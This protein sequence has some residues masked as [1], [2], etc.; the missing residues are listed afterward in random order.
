MNNIYL[1]ELQLQDY[2][3]EEAPPIAAPTP[4]APTPAAPTPAAPTPAAPAVQSAPSPTAPT[5]NTPNLTQS[6]QSP[7][8]SAEQGQEQNPLTPE[9]IMSKGQEYITQNKLSAGMKTQYA[10]APSKN[11]EVYILGVGGQEV[12]SVPSRVISLAGV[13]GLEGKKIP[14][15]HMM[16]VDPAM[17]S[18]YATAG[19][20][21][22]AGQKAYNQKGAEQ[23]MERQKA[24]RTA[25]PPAPL[26]LEEDFSAATG[27]Q[28]GSYKPD[29]TNVEAIYEHMIL[30]EQVAKPILVSVITGKPGAYTY[31][32]GTG[33]GK[34][35]T[36]TPQPGSTEA[37]PGS[38]EPIPES[39]KAA[40]ATP[41]PTFNMD[42]RYYL[43]I[44]GKDMSRKFEWKKLK[45]QE[46]RATFASTSNIAKAIQN[47]QRYVD[48][49][50]PE[51]EEQPAAASPTPP[52]PTGTSTPAGTPAPVE[53]PPTTPAVES[54]DIYAGGSFNSLF[55]YIVYEQAQTESV[56]IDNRSVTKPQILQGVSYVLS[57]PNNVKAGASI[58]EVLDQVVGT[59][60]Y[61]LKLK[62][63]FDQIYK[64]QIKNVI[65]NKFIPGIGTIDLNKQTITPEA[66]AG[67]PASAPITINIDGF[68]TT[69]GT[70]MTEAIKNANTSDEMMNAI[71]PEVFITKL[72]NDK[73]I[74][75][76]PAP[77][78]A[79]IFKDKEGMAK[80]YRMNFF[81]P[82]CDAL[83]KTQKTSQKK[84]NIEQWSN[85]H[86]MIFDNLC[87]PPNDYVL[88]LTEDQWNDILLGGSKVGSI[89]GALTSIAKNF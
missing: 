8:A 24:A 69:L 33:A 13:K 41:N 74:T 84:V 42:K 32:T 15:G 53:A 49:I 31:T 10:Y 27:A 46:L 11:I 88:Y 73:V 67:Q 30:L 34:P 64:G 23:G 36:E 20:K 45:D 51:G 21:A 26:E 18:K 62:E 28:F 9:E 48:S 5:A 56:T 38:A 43:N 6:T 39:T 77:A 85:V 14:Q 7:S 57:D 59:G 25:T 55:E 29:L 76:P 89:L 78:V 65:N 86:K 81:K 82:I 22:V 66:P 87:N 54:Y 12:G 4:A 63:Q 44:A 68:I 61:F 50:A 1:K 47:L 60:E 16:I 79:D 75:T 72:Y 71:D 37:P 17:A 19:S 80:S 35:I 3:I 52:A 58:D 83:G 70:T 2:L 40:L